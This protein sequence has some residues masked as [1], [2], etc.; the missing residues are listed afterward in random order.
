M[1]Y[2]YIWF[3]N[4]FSKFAKNSG[5]YRCFRICIK[6]VKGIEYIDFITRSWVFKEYRSIDNSP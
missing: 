5:I 3:L 2:I 4:P 1:K 6:S